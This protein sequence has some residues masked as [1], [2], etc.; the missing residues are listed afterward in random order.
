[1]NNRMRGGEK[2]NV[3][4]KKKRGARGSRGVRVYCGG[5]SQRRKRKNIKSIV[6]KNCNKLKNRHD[7]E[8][9]TTVK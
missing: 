8:T 5:S 3:R 1:M 2:R 9:R 6:G 4:E 7:E